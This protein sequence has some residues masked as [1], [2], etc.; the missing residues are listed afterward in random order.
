[1]VSTHFHVKYSDPRLKSYPN[2]RL[3]IRFHIHFVFK[4]GNGF[5]FRWLIENPTSGK[6]GRPKKGK[7][8]ALMERLQKCKGA[9]CLFIG[10]FAVPFDNNQA[11]RDI[12]N[13]MAFHFR[14]TTSLP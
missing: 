9:V 10:D 1:M 5:R 11:E 8:R 12:R 14:P 13:V 6:R 3:N 4:I 2:I 7:V